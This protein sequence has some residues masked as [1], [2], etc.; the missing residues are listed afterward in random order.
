MPAVISRVQR[1][2]R[3]Q[4]I[5]QA[6]KPVQLGELLTRFRGLKPVASAVQVQVDV[7]PVNLL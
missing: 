1:F 3:M 5:L 6:G 2:H 7:D 4:I